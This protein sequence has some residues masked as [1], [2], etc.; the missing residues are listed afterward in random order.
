MRAQMT[1]GLTG[2]SPMLIWS[3]NH[4]PLDPDVINN[5]QLYKAFYAVPAP[6]SLP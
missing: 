2:A 1:G 3:Q 4:N 6:A 5:S